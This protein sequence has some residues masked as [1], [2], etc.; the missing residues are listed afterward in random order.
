MRKRIFFKLISLMLIP[1]F[2]L[3]GFSSSLIA[4]TLN[5]KPEQKTTL[6]PHISLKL[7]DIQQAYLK[8][9]ID[10]LNK[11]SQVNSSELIGKN[12]MGKNLPLLFKKLFPQAADKLIEFFVTQDHAELFGKFLKNTKQAQTPMVRAGI[13]TA[14]AEIKVETEHEKEVLR[15][16][17]TPLLDSMSMP[18]RIAANYVLNWMGNAEEKITSVTKLLQAAELKVN[19]Y[20]LENINLAIKLLAQCE[21]PVNMQE[22]LSFRIAQVQV[23]GIGKGVR[24]CSKILKKTGLTIKAAKLYDRL[25]MDTHLLGPDRFELIE[26]LAVNANKHKFLQKIARKVME[27]AF[28]VIFLG[29]MKPSFSVIWQLKTLK[30]ESIDENEERW[31]LHKSLARAFLAKFKTEIKAQQTNNVIQIIRNYFLLQFI[32]DAQVYS[33]IDS[34]LM[35]VKELEA[36]YHYLIFYGIEKIYKNGKVE[37]WEVVNNFLQQYEKDS[38]IRKA[39]LSLENFPSP[40]LITSV[41]MLS[42]D[43]VNSLKKMITANDPKVALRAME[44]VEGSLYFNDELL[45]ILAEKADQNTPCSYAATVALFKCLLKDNNYNWRVKKSFMQLAKAADLTNIF[46]TPASQEAMDNILAVR[47]GKITPE[48]RA[49]Q[50]V[51]LLNFSQRTEKEK[52]FIRLLIQPYLDTDDLPENMVV[53]IAANYVLNKVGTAEDRVKSVEYI[54]SQATKQINGHNSERLMVALE[55]LS[56][57]DI[58]DELKPRVSEKI[59][60]VLTEEKITYFYD[61]YANILEKTG[62]SKNAAELIVESNIIDDLMRDIHRFNFSLIEFLAN[63]SHKNSKLKNKIK[64]VIQEDKKYTNLSALVMISHMEPD[65]ELF[66][67]F[68]NFLKWGA[69]LYVKI[70][71]AFLLK[72]KYDCV[73]AGDNQAKELVLEIDDILER[74]YQNKFKDTTADMFS[75]AIFPI[76]GEIEELIKKESTIRLLGKMQEEKHF[77]DLSKKKTN[78]PIEA[79]MNWLIKYAL[80]ESNISEARNHALYA[81]QQLQNS[82]Y[83]YDQEKLTFLKSIIEIA[84]KRHSSHDRALT[85]KLICGFDLIHRDHKESLYDILLRNAYSRDYT[86]YLDNVEQI[87]FELNQDPYKYGIFNGGVNPIIKMMFS[88]F[89]NSRYEFFKTRIAF[90]MIFLDQRIQKE[91][92]IQFSELSE[93]VFDYVLTQPEY[94]IEIPR[95]PDSENILGAQKK[96]ENNLSE[97]FPASN[98]QF[99]SPERAGKNILSVLYN[100]LNSAKGFNVQWPQVRD[101]DSLSENVVNFVLN[102]FAQGKIDEQYF[103]FLQEVYNQ[104]TEAQKKELINKQDKFAQNLLNEFI[105]E[106]EVNREDKDKLAK[107]FKTSSFSEYHK[108]VKYFQMIGRLAGKNTYALIIKNINSRFSQIMQ[109]NSNLTEQRFEILLAA[110]LIASLGEVQRKPKLPIY[111]NILAWSRIASISS[112]GYLSELGGYANETLGKLAAK[113][114]VNGDS[115]QG[116]LFYRIRNFLQGILKTDQEKISDYMFASL[117]AGKGLAIM[118]TGSLDAWNGMFYGGDLDRGGFGVHPWVKKLLLTKQSFLEYCLQRFDDAAYF[119]TEKEWIRTT[120]IKLVIAHENY[121]KQQQKDYKAQ[122]GLKLIEQYLSDSYRKLSYDEEIFN[123]LQKNENICAHGFKILTKY[124]NVKKFSMKY[125]WSTTQKYLQAVSSY[126]NSESI[127]LLLDSYQIANLEES[128]FILAQFKKS[129]FNHEQWVKF[130]ELLGDC[131]GQG[132]ESALRVLFYTA[133]K[134][135]LKSYKKVLKGII[136]TQSLDK[137]RKNL[138]AMAKTALAILNNRNRA[139]AKNIIRAN[140]SSREALSMLD[141]LYENSFPDRRLSIFRNIAAQAQNQD[142]VNKAISLLLKNSHQLKSTTL[143]QRLIS[144]LPKVSIKSIRQTLGFNKS[145]V[146][147][148]SQAI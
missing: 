7:A 25:F 145:P 43:K 52:G 58:P 76:D 120:V 47:D 82:V 30:K 12:F 124:F 141:I 136:E 96:L 8:E 27:P 92:N 75:K 135:K 84:Y 31:R 125:S 114:L 127:Q 14:L 59:T 137:D 55:L 49:G 21:I 133:A 68:E 51:S 32:G 48:V 143:A 63:N 4:Q 80:E 128:V 123:I 132:R 46:I 24:G 126:P 88:D 11:I 34:L 39:N 102:K 10:V 44:Q 98:G 65:A 94:L 69:P 56:E 38:D 73:R 83:F 62:L 9:G 53:K 60:S 70:A 16:L 67:V 119:M 111:E 109:P 17:I 116:G 35:R 99:Y 33:A 147:L 22:D 64:K 148:I 146:S 112:N 26:M 108:L 144:K 23:K 72:I 89:N 78:E 104:S 19:E 36:R 107:L 61:L 121:L 87:F 57:C 95:L 1:S 50:I 138:V 85:T 81:I 66:F 103:E 101:T 2:I 106:F 122:V 54:L 131:L 110:R 90:Q 100:A 117:G 97:E 6:S 40:A 37:N 5:N 140:L 142:V 74:V 118:Q 45:L 139:A 130:G 18:E 3:T 134:M 41:S 28:Y 29:N 129:D 113:Y 20:S 93:K 105:T 13:I 15:L 77:Y 115:E 71:Y 79:A 91:A 42:P 86:V